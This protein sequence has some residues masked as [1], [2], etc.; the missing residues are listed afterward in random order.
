[1]SRGGTPERIGAVVESYLAQRGLLAI[2]R[3]QEALA[4]WPSLVG[5]Q[6]AAASEGVRVERGVLYVRARSAAWRQELAYLKPQLLD[7][8]RAKCATLSD[9][10]FC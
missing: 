8:V 2:C 1:M 5:P 6:I 9:I 4:A 10:V 7:K 3:E